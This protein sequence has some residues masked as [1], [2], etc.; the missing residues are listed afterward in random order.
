MLSA[1]SLSA[2]RSAASS[3]IVLAER[4]WFAPSATMRM[5]RWF[6]SSAAARI[7]QTASV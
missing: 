1:K 4:E 5:A 2:I 6:D 3:A 7:H